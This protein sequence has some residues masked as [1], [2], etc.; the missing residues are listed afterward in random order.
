M[1]RRGKKLENP[2][3]GDIYILIDNAAIAAASCI[4]SDAKTKFEALD[5]PTSRRAYY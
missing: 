5:A 2:A 3:R 4:D 1:K